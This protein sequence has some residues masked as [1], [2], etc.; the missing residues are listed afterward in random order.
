MLHAV[1]RS[2][3]DLPAAASNQADQQVRLQGMHG[4]LNKLWQ[5]SSHTTL[6]LPLSLFFCLLSPFSS[7]LLSL[8]LY[9]VVFGFP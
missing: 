9:W 5:P 7:R 2:V 3:N 1:R 6:V 8:G 4:K